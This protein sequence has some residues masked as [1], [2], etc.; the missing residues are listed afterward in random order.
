[1]SHQVRYRGR[2]ISVPDDGTPLLQHLSGHYS[3]CKQGYCGAC[4]T[5]LKQG[6]VRYL[7]APMAYTRP[8]EILPCCC[9]PVTDLELE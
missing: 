6:E 1:M 4:K 3:E 7:T 9:R 5:T 2:H 8:G